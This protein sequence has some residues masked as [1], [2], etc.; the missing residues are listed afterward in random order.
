MSADKGHRNNGVAAQ[1]RVPLTEQSK[2]LDF[3]SELEIA[4]LVTIAHFYQYHRPCTVSTLI[5]FDKILAQA[6]GP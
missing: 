2:T 6:S 5:L 4:Q 1:R 3:G